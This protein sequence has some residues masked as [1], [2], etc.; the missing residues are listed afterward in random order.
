MTRSATPTGARCTIGMARLGSA[1][2]GPGAPHVDLAD[3][4]NI[5]MRDF[6]G[7]GGLGD[8]LGG[9]G[10]GRSG[11]DIKRVAELTLLDVAHGLEQV[12]PVKLL[13]VCDSCEGSGAEPGSRQS[14]VRHAREAAR[15]AEPSDRSLDSS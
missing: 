2:A 9:R 3:A 11:G 7:F 14:R 1:A 6:G 8:L 13:D 4:L 5:F 12:F 15:F 10:Q